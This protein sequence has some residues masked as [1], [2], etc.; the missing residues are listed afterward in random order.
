MP[1][2]GFVLEYARDHHDHNASN[3]SRNGSSA[4]GSRFADDDDNNA[5]GRQLLIAK[6]GRGYGCRMQGPVGH[7][8]ISKSSTEFDRSQAVG[9][10]SRIALRIFERAF[11]RSGL[12]LPP[13][14]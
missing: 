5:Y 14:D 11:L 6:A 4:T 7:L 8:R 2:A 1:D 9:C 13:P 3:H 12:P 10:K